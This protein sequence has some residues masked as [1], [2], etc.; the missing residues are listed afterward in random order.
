MSVVG[1]SN[2][3][4]ALLGQYLVA[5]AWDPRRLRSEWAEYYD[6]SRATMN[7]CLVEAS[8]EW[9]Y[10][11]NQQAKGGAFHTNSYPIILGHLLRGEATC[12]QRLTPTYRSEFVSCKVY[13]QNATQGLSS[14][15]GE[16]DLAVARVQ[17]HDL[18]NL[19]S[20]MQSI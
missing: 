13:L 5:L 14:R 7:N 10:S 20:R 15:S 18:R 8:N 16:V 9:V 12:L 3:S 17:M 1:T 11:H 2:I 4:D 6:D 19:L